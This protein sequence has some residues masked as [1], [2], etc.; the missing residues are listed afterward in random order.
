MMV[1]KGRLFE[2]TSKSCIK[3]GEL[4][5]RRSS[6]LP[7]QWVVTSC[8]RLLSYVKSQSDNEVEQFADIDCQLISGKLNSPLVMT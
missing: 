3:S 7:L 1:A 5:I 6:G 4:V 2:D 8:T